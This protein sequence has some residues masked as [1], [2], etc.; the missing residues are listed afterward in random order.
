MLRFA[1]TAREAKRASEAERRAAEA[2]ATAEEAKAKTARS[3]WTAGGLRARETVARD[4]RHREEI[5]GRWDAVTADARRSA[6]DDRGEDAEDDFESRR[7]GYSAD[8]REDAREVERGHSNENRIARRAS[9]TPPGSDLRPHP[10]PR[11]R[12]DA[13]GAASSSRGG[14]RAPGGDEAAAVLRHPRERRD[15]D[16]FDDGDDRA[17]RDDRGRDGG[18]DDRGRDDRGRDDRGRDDRGRDRGR[19]RGDGVTRAGSGG[20]KTNKGWS[21]PPWDSSSLQPSQAKTRNPLHARASKLRR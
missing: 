16:G 6:R 9:P 2:E 19:E 14:R 3:R 10:R 11:P 21:P 13:R 7:A 1:K 18:R 8:A 17:R 15:R 5:R 12:G 4:E 20:K